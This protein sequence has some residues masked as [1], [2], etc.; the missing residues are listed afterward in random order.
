MPWKSRWQ[1][2]IP[3]CSLPTYLFQTPTVDLSDKPL[4]I[5]AARPEYALSHASY[6]LWSQ[7]LATGL[8]EHGFQPG[9]RLLLFS[10]NTLFFPVVLMG[11]I[12]AGGVFTGA[13]PGYVARELAYQI[14]DSGAKVL[15]AAEGSLDVALEAAKEANF[16]LESVYSFDNGYATLSGQSP[17]SQGIQRWS[18]LLASPITASTFAWPTYATFADMQTTA[19]LNYSSGTTGVPKGVEI[20]HMN[21]ISNCLQ[22]EY[23]SS[24]GV[25]SAARIARARGLSMLPMYHAYGQTLHCISFP[26]MGVPVYIMQKYDFIAMLEYVQKYRITVLTLVPPIVVAMAKRPETRQYDLSSVEDVGSGAAPLGREASQEFEALWPTN[27]V[28]CKQGWGMT[29]LTCTACGTEP[30]AVVTDTSVG[31]LNPNLEAMIVNN[32]EEEVQI[33]ERGEFWVRGPNVM[34]GYW[35]RPEETRETKTVEGWLKTGDIV[36][37]NEKGMIYVVDRKKVGSMESGRWETCLLTYRPGRNSSRS[38]ATK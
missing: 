14:K 18:T 17:G 20:T 11:T 35:G 3:T 2:D 28:N 24:L 6:R 25:D 30:D 4:L 38:K 7:R 37:R 32:E 1:V 9:D 5:D 36:Y 15:I 21:Y 33:G 29:E 8:K 10:G 19:V 16:P 31:E 22:T 26:L 13:N 34:K 27:K 12:M 23:V